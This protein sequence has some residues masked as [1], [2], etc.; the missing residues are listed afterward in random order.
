MSHSR[1]RPAC[2]EIS[3]AVGAPPLSSASD[4]SGSMIV[5]VRHDPVHDFL[6]PMSDHVIM[7]YN[8]RVQRI[9]RRTGKSVVRGTLRPGGVGIIA[10]GSDSWWGVP[11]PVEAVQLYLPPA[12]LKRVASE[13]DMIAQP[14]LRDRTA[15]S[16]PLLARL[17]QGAV[18]VLDGNDPLDS[19]FRQQ[20][21]ELISTRLLI[22]HTGSSSPFQSV[23]GGLS[24]QVLRRAIERLRSD[25][26][27][28][29]SLSAL[30]DEAGLSRFHFCRAFKVSTGLSPHTWLRQ[31]RIDQAMELL[32]NPDIPVSSVASELGYGSQTA[33]AAAFRRMTGQS[34]TEWRQD[35]SQKIR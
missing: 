16:D 18:D 21:T 7:V 12:I 27:A 22:A 13:A 8:G 24:P 35:V 19:L 10:A 30:A 32:R 9:E 25:N 15:Y 5:H 33:F 4:I 2:P 26:D 3:R 6:E 31:F 28:D 17:L 14:E 20:L 29:V 34:P 23:V 11:E 1:L